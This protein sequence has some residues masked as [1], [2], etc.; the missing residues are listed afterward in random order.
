MRSWIFS[1]VSVRVLPSGSLRGGALTLCCFLIHLAAWCTCFGSF[2]SE[3]ILR[4][5]SS[6]AFLMTLARFLLESL[7][8]KRSSGSS[9][10][11]YFRSFHSLLAL[12]CSATA[13]SHSL[14]H[15]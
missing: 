5:K 12:W 9:A 2:N 15:H 7:R 4:K 13:L 8:T 6:L 10:S 3:I 14:V 1:W 11:M